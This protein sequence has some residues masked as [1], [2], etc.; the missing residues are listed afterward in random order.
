MTLDGGKGDFH[1]DISG[2]SRVR[3]SELLI[4]YFD[5]KDFDKK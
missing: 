5:R 4:A 1:S 2:T 3:R